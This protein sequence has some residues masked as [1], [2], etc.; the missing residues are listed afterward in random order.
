MASRC[1]GSGRLVEEIVKVSREALT[2]L[3]DVSLDGPL[4]ALG[5]ERYAQPQALLMAMAAN[6]LGRVV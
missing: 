2:R 5:I 1:E 4:G 3:D 6:E